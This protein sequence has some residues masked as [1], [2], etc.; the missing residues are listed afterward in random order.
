[1][2][3]GLTPEEGSQ[4]FVAP[5]IQEIFDKVVKKKRMDLAIAIKNN[6]AMNLK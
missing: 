6:T 5:F 4:Y 3:L 1:M 2:D